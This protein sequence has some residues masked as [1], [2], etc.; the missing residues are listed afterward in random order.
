MDHLYH[1]VG[2]S[3]KVV[4]SG[5]A[6]LAVVLNRGSLS[7]SYFV[8]FALGNALFGKVIII[9]YSESMDFY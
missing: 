7:A 3:A 1:F 2:T 6:A 5:S 8:V 4:V 9:E